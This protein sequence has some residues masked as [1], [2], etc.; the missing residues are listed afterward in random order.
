MNVSELLNHEITNNE[1][2]I[3][4]NISLTE[5]MNIFNKLSEEKK[6]FKYLRKLAHHIDLIANVP[7]RNVSRKPTKL[8]LKISR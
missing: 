3:G 6:K 1:L 7:V 8:Q 4:A 5:A 2:I